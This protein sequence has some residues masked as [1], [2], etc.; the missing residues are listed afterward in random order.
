MSTITEIFP[1][2][3]NFNTGINTADQQ[4]IKL[5]LLIN[6][7]AINLDDLISVNLLR[8]IKKP[9]RLQRILVKSFIRIMTMIL[10]HY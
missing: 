9:L 7:V 3:D 8:L 2:N 1:W 6:K 10:R 5:V 4:H